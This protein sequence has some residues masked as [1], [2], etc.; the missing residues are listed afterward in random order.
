MSQ[1]DYI[2]IISTGKSRTI[3]TLSHIYLSVTRGVGEEENAFQTVIYQKQIIEHN[4]NSVIY[5]PLPSC[6]EWL[7]ESFPT[8]KNTT[9]FKNQSH[10]VSKDK[11]RVN[12][13][14]R[15]YTKI[16]GMLAYK[17]TSYSRNLFLLAASSS[18]SYRAGAAGKWTYCWKTLLCLTYLNLL[19]WHTYQM[20]PIN[21]NVL[22]WGKGP[23][24]FLSRLKARRS[25][26]PC[27]P[28]STL[29]T[30]SKFLS[31]LLSTN[32]CSLLSEDMNTS[33]RRR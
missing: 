33:I 13:K 25:L 22:S 28:I 3:S 27:P 14:W 31:R 1:N 29:T 5:N 12:R 17:S 7:K 19:C 24:V 30:D 11:S 26:M 18:D 2:P 15:N 16:T 9:Y 10:V 23:T 8:Q 21:G 20:A 4:S 6:V 32:A